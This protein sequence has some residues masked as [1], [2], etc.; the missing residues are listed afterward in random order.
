M[1]LPCNKLLQ[2]FCFEQSQ[3]RTLDRCFKINYQVGGLCRLLNKKFVITGNAI[4]EIPPMLSRR[5][6]VL[7]P[8]YV[9][10]NS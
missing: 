7:N 1:H 9:E 4:L 8:L 5:K 2:D 10:I 3:K 6:M